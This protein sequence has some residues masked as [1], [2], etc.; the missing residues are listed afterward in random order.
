MST[1]DIHTKATKESKHNAKDTVKGKDKKE[2]KGHRN[3]PKTIKGHHC[4]SIQLLQYKSARCSIKRHRAAEWI[5][6]RTIYMLPK[7]NF[8]SSQR[9]TGRKRE[10][11]E[12]VYIMNEM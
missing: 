12:K 4:K 6:T 11:M 9:H 5:T 3:N 10:G 8:T 2:Q 1:Q 7:R